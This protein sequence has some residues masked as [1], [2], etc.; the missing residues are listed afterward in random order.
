[1]AAINTF[2]QSY[3]CHNNYLRFFFS[4]FLGRW[5]AYGRRGVACGVL[6]SDPS[7]SL[8]SNSCLQ[9]AK[10]YHSHGDW[11]LHYL[12]TLFNYIGYVCSTKYNWNIVMNPEHIRKQRDSHGP[13]QGTISAFT[14]GDGGTILLLFIYSCLH[15]LSF[16]M[17]ISALESSFHHLLGV[18]IFVLYMCNCMLCLATHSIYLVFL[19]LTIHSTAIIKKEQ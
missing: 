11:F 16:I 10:I 4:C 5:C 19:P 13:F 3:H 15:A 1:M 17:S 12:T 2:F 14:C 6:W 18:L 8:S 9:K 7:S